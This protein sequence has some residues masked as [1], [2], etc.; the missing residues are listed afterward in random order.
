LAQLLQKVFATG[1]DD[2]TGETVQGNYADDQ[3]KENTMNTINNLS[4]EAQLAALQAENAKLHADLEAKNKPKTTR[5][6]IGEKLSVQISPKGVVSVY[7]LNSRFP[8]SLYPDQ[9]MKLFSTMANLRAFIEANKEILTKIETER[10]AADEAA[11]AAKA[12]KQA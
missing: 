2:A 7:G 10:K 1:S 9:W 11:E 4:L 3:T 6:S 8:V 5:P 12:T